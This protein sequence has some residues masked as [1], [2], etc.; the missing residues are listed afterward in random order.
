MSYF[1]IK[2]SH[3]LQYSNSEASPQRTVAVDLHLKSCQLGYRFLQHAIRQA[4]ITKKS[5]LISTWMVSISTEVLLELVTEGAK[6]RHPAPA[7]AFSAKGCQEK[8]RHT[9]PCH[10]LFSQHA[11]HCLNP[12]LTLLSQM[13]EGSYADNDLVADRALRRRI[14]VNTVQVICNILTCPQAFR[15]CHLQPHRII[16]L[17]ELLCPCFLYSMN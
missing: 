1:L 15:S 6:H 4:Y 17:C 7:T 8:L 5:K 14:W 3:I 2:P 9:G 11:M 16:C 13:G 10:C 12:G